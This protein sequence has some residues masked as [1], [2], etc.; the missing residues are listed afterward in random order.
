MEE[1]KVED[2]VD[3]KSSSSSSSRKQQQNKKKKKQKRTTKN[4]HEHAAHAR[5]G[6]RHRHTRRKCSG[7]A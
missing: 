1:V 4:Q 3:D 6:V 7:A 2:V 5:I